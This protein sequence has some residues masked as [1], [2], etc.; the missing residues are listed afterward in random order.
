LSSIVQYILSLQSGQFES[1]IASAGSAVDGLESKIGSLGSA[2]GL[3]FG[4]AGASMFAK[5]MID[6]GATVE[7]ALTGL[8]TLLQNS[9]EAQSVITNTMED[10]TKTPFAFEG[11]LAA[12]KALISADETATGAREAV[13]N[14][15]NAIAATGGGDD[16]LQR[17]VVNLQQIKNVGFASALDLK[18][19]AYAGINLYKV[20]DEAGIKHGKKQEVTYEQITTALKKAH[21]EGGIYFNGLE[22]M[23]GNTS[24]QISNLG[25]AMF[26][27]KVQMFNDLKPVITATIETLSGFISSL[28]DAWDWAVKH[29]TEIKAL[30]IGWGAARLAAMTLIPLIEGLTVATVSATTATAGL[31][32]AETAL[33]GPIGLVITAVGLLAAA[34]VYM[35]DEAERAKISQQG[36]TDQYNKNT[37]DN[38][39]ED[40]Q[41]LIAKGM[42][43]NA[44][45]KKISDDRRSFYEDDLKRAQED[46]NLGL[47][48]KRVLQEA[49]LLNSANDPSVSIE[50]ARGRVLRAQGSLDEL[51]NFSKAKALSTS[52]AKAGGVTPSKTSTAS[53]AVGSKS[54]TINV[55]IQKFGETTINA[56]TIKE[57]LSKMGDQVQAAL[58]GAINDFRIVAGQ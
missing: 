21:E 19:F 8:T 30:A 50:E 15:S 17:M 46:L 33:L 51:G 55:S 9:R 44:A 7:N 45:R 42:N 49:G 53:K 35:G 48:R 47:E 4:L 12:N 54:I 18:Q 3:T 34:Y 20:L 56:T 52:N 41:G 28:R 13:L 38:L 57:G 37:K 26:Q 22:N 31:A 23:A 16:E 29:R 1:G 10:A 24:V 43:E 40:L 25:D 5:S 58:M 39:E 2:I 11:L 32:V 27:L 6:A 36:L 14:L